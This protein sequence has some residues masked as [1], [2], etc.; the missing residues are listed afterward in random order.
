MPRNPRSGQPEQTTTPGGNLVSNAISQNTEAARLAAK[1]A[2][3]VAGD[4]GD[5]LGGLL[6]GVVDAL[7]GASKRFKIRNSV[8]IIVQWE[9]IDKQVRGV[10][11]M[12]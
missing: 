6:D 4:A 3:E 8:L 11:Y 12:R 2:K 5:F 9:S 7:G 10:Q 1:Q